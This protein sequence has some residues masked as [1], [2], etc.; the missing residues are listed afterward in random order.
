LTTAG[1]KKEAKSGKE[2][3]DNKRVGRGTISECE[4]HR[5]ERYVGR[6]NVGGK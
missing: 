2:M 5:W 3:K 1:T 4:I 6:K